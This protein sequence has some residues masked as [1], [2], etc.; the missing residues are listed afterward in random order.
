M[1]SFLTSALLAELYPHIAGT[2]GFA[3]TDTMFLIFDTLLASKIAFTVPIHYR[4]WQISL[5]LN[6]SNIKYGY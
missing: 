3:H 4:I 1:L 5:P 6:L 2:G